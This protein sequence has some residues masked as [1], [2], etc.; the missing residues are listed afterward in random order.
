MVRSRR[1]IASD[2]WL[3]NSVHDV[4]DVVCVNVVLGS[5]IVIIGNEKKKG[6][7]E[8]NGGRHMS[9]EFVRYCIGPF[10]CDRGCRS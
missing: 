1:R 10:P 7:K 4:G 3:G 5:F 2:L 9:S 8:M 6:L